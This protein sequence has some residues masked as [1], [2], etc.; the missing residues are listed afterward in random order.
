MFLFDYLSKHGKIMYSYR[1]T[2][3]YERMPKVINTIRGQVYELLKQEICDGHYQPGQWLQEKELAEQFSVSRSPVRE[4]LKQLAA[5]GLVIEVPN[6]GVFIREFTPKDIEE[7][8]DLR[9]M[10]ESYAI[11]KIVD[12]LTEDAKAQLSAC[13]DQLQTAFKQ[14][15]LTQYIQADTALHDLIIRLSGNSFL[16]IAYERVHIMIQQFR[17]YSL[18]NQG[19]FDESVEEHQ[20]IVHHILAGEPEQAKKI[21]SRHLQLAKEQIII[22]LTGQNSSLP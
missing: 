2:G 3:V 8:F 15:Q 17:T 1:R 10:M 9:V 7:I 16:A 4:A 11:D 18:Q 21:N 12:L 13:L 6:K 20:N 22:Y 5:D 14:N 19:R